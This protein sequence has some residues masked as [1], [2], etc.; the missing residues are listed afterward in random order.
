MKTATIFPLRLD[1]SHMLFFSR[2][3]LPLGL[4]ILALFAF[5]APSGLGQAYV[6]GKDGRQYSGN[7]IQCSSKGLTLIAG[8]GKKQ[9]VPGSFVKAYKPKPR[10]L[11]QAEQL[12]FSGKGAQATA[13]LVQIMKENQ[14]LEWEQRAAVLL[15]RHF[16]DTNNPA[17][18][19][20]VVTRYMALHGATART[21]PHIIGA[22]ID[23]A[24]ANN[25]LPN[26]EIE[27]GRIE[28]SKN[29][30]MAAVAQMRRGDV[31]LKR[32]LHEAAV[33][34]YLRAVHE[35]SEIADP[36]VAAETYYRAGL[37]L[38]A[39]KDAPRSDSMY[40]KAAGYRGTVYGSLARGRIR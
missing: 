20:E 12:V 4:T 11:A 1:S 7:D 10:N 34:E 26:A 35:Y 21:N 23:V 31:E 30:N 17:K 13:A 32:G 33:L 14:Y 28:D 16:L 40:K 29:P 2:S 3:L 39:R 19:D 9:F 25:K 8:A 36:E 22:K 15:A 6:I 38:A 5:T 37:G 18:A 27:I 24:I